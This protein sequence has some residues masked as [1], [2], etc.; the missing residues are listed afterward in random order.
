[1]ALTNA[2]R[3]LALQALIGSNEIT[4]ISP[5]PAGTPIASL[6]SGATASALFTALLTAIGT[7]FDVYLTDCLT[8]LGQL[9]SA[10]LS[11]VDAQASVVQA[12]LALTVVH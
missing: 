1:M 5:I 2:Q 6:V 11:E 4:S 8:A 3:Q 7:N 12:N 10:Q 9:Y